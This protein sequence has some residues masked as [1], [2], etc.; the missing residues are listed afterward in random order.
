[1]QCQR[2]AQETQTIV[3]E[4]EP[5]GLG[6]PTGTPGDE[7][8]SGLVGESS[9][10]PHPGKALEGFTRPEEDG[11]RLARW[12]ADDVDAG[13]DSIASV[14]VEASRRTEHRA[15]AGRWPSVG[16][17]C[18]ILAFTEIGFHL[19]EPQHQALPGF[20]PVDQTAAD[21]VGCDGE[22]VSCEE[23]PTQGAT[24]GHASSIGNRIGCASPEALIRSL[25]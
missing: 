15:I 12:A 24:E 11:A 10:C 5:E 21:K 2:G 25:A 1:M 4:A 8:R 19:D 20:E 13:M 22:D 6:E 23:G 16:V 18:R 9:E 14:G 7:G 17:G 3:F